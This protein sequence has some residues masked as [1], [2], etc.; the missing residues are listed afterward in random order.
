MGIWD[1]I[2]GAFQSLF[3]P[4]D[5]RRSQSPSNNIFILGSGNTVNIDQKSNRLDININKALEEKPEEFAEAF[6]KAVW[7]EGV[8]VFDEKH[9][10]RILDVKKTELPV[11]DAEILDF[12]RD[13][14]PQDDIRILRSATYIHKLYK[15]RDP[16]APRFKRELRERYGPRANN[17]VNMW[18]ASYIK[19]LVVPLHEELKS[20][21]GA[22]SKFRRTY[23]VIVSQA[24]FSVFVAS[25]MSEKEI[26]DR[27][28]FQI[29]QNIRLGQNYINIHGIGEGLIKKIR[30]L[31][32]VLEED[33]KL[34][35][36]K[37]EELSGQA[38]FVKLNFSPPPSPSDPGE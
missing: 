25:A 23:E 19:K 1:R 29:S 20:V 11:K 28:R 18:S 13:K 31:I 27:V 9:R 16:E 37:K 10:D 38:L 24:A 5:T 3:G 34:Q 36:T 22:P 35:F 32:D 2:V 21:D 15:D 4:A 6:Q 14:I 17:L 26:E 12:L 30:A 7:V 8:P 33:E